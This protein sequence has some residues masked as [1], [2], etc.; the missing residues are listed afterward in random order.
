MPPA[1]RIAAQMREASLADF[2]ANI[3]PNR[4]PPNRTDVDPALGSRSS[5]LRSDSGYLTYI[6]TTRPM[7]YG[8]LLKYRKG[9]SW[10]EATTTPASARIWSDTAIKSHQVGTAEA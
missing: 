3:G 6:I 10:Y 8:E 5:T 7:T 9:C 1:L 2:G 4:F